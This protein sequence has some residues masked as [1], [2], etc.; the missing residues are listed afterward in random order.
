MSAPKEAREIGTCQIPL[1]GIVDYPYVIHELESTEWIRE[2]AKHEGWDKKLEEWKFGTVEGKVIIGRVPRY[3]QKGDIYHLDCRHPYLIVHIYSIDQI[4]T[5]DNIK[6]IDS[7]VEVSFD[8]TSRR[9]RIIRKTLSPKYDSQIAIPLRFNSKN[10]IN[11]E[12]FGKK[13]RI[14]IDVWGKT[15][16]IIYIGGISITPYEMFFN[17]KNTKRRKTKLEYI[18][19]ETNIK[20]NYETVVYKGCKKL[21]FLHDDQRVSNIHFSMWTYPDMLCVENEYNKIYSPSFYNINK[22][23]PSKLSEKY[24]KL[25]ILYI[26]VLKTIRAI[27]DNINDISKAKRYFNFELQNQRKEFHFLPTFLT[28]VKS[29]YYAES[30]NAIFHYVRCV[31]FIHKKENIIF[32]PDFTLQLKGGNAIDHSL[33]LC[34]LFLGIPV[35]TFVCFGT[36]WDGQKHAWVA[37]LEYNDVKN[38]G[39][40]KFWE[41]TTG[42]IYI[43]KKRIHNVNKLKSLNIKLNESKYKSHLRNGFIKKNG[44]NLD[45]NKIKEETKRH[46][47]ELFQNRTKEIP[48]GG[49]SLPYKTIDILFNNKNIYVNLQDSSPLNIWYDFWKFDFWFPFTSIE[50]N[51]KPCFT[52]KSFSHKMEDM[53]LDRVAKE[54]RNN[55]EK[56]INIY[57][58]SRNLC[59]RWNR[60]ETLELFLQ[61]GLEL[62]HQLNTSRKEDTLLAKVKIDDW[63]KALYHKVPQSHRLLGFPYHFNTCKSQFISDKLISTLGILESRDRS[64]CL[65]LAA[66]RKAEI[67]NSKKKKALQEKEQIEEGAVEQNAQFETAEDIDDLGIATPDHLGDTLKDDP[68]EEGEKEAYDYATENGEKKGDVSMKT[69]KEVTY[70]QNTKKKTRLRKSV[71]LVN[72]ILTMKNKENNK[73]DEN[74]NLFN[75]IREYIPSDKASQSNENEFV[76]KDEM[77]ENDAVEDDLHEGGCIPGD[78]TDMI[79]N[80][81]PDA[82]R[83]DVPQLG[84]NSIIAGTKRDKKKNYLTED[85]REDGEKNGRDDG[86]KNGRE[87]GEKNGREDGGENDRENVR[88]GTKERKKSKRGKEKK[89]EKKLEFEKLLKSNNYFE[90]EKKK[91]QEDIEKLEKEKEEFRMQKIMREEKEKQL[92]LEEKLKLE[93]EK[94][95]FENEKLKRK[96]SLMLKMNEWEKKEQETRER[97]ENYRKMLEQTQRRGDK[98]KDRGK[99]KKRGKKKERMQEREEGGEGEMERE[100]DMKD[101]QRDVERGME[102]ERERD[103]ERGMELEMKKDMKLEMDRELRELRELQEDRRRSEEMD[104]CESTN[105]YKDLSSFDEKLDLNRIYTKVSSMSE[106]DACIYYRRYVLIWLHP[107][108][109]SYVCTRFSVLLKIMHGSFL[110]SLLFTF[111]DLE[112][113]T[114]QKKKIIKIHTNRKENSGNS[115]M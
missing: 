19:L 57:R 4:V 60:D 85:A 1:K 46:I 103:M 82:H 95:M 105:E 73:G 110:P 53:E 2:E 102:L 84:T 58:A 67:R 29:P 31:P 93:K 14:Y 17:E 30:A 62:L 33:L 6:E 50:Y 65:S 13:G 115:Q 40:V 90:R 78:T 27:P 20:I 55:I 61:V 32:T 86:E 114:G 80:D 79:H 52:I 81:E 66:Q 26:E 64:L 24:E 97:E 56:N 83:T 38:Y 89:K 8:E 98:E 88:A 51:L 36:L 72:L 109:N 104:E 45:V 59:T 39:I 77:G 47:K 113:A 5:V 42:N 49:P 96:V 69:E 92:L 35:I 99:K 91:L 7:Y 76:K 94:E 71:D 111:I 22:N 74:D 108:V 9:S 75:K 37:T 101:R 25:K 15:D 44:I 11:Y 100:W 28:N 48:I 18:D 43:L 68:F 41:T 107:H 34:S 12:H 10:D 87:D 112:D 16:E 21:V 70:S 63:K 54:L 106:R 23:L 3:R